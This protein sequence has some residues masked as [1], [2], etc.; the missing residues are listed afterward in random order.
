MNPFMSS[1]PTTTLFSERT[2]RGQR[3]TA[4][5]A[6]IVVHAAVAGLVSFG[7]LYTPRLNSQAAQHYVVR[8]L[9]LHTPDELMQR[10]ASG[11]DYPGPWP[12][13]NAHAQ[14][15][16][17]EAHPRSLRQVAQAKPGPQTL[18]QPDLPTQLALTQP[19]PVPQIVI[20]SPSKALVKNIVAPKPEKPTAADVPPSLE[21]PNEAVNLADVEIAPAPL[22]QAKLPI[23]PSTTSPITVHAPDLAPMAPATVSQLSSQP[24]PVAVMSLSDLRMA[25]GAVTLPPVN[26]TAS[27]KAAGALAP[28][29]AKDSALPGNGNPAGA[30]GGP[31]AA[32]TPGSQASSSQAPGSGAAAGK[33]AG[34][35]SGP[36]QGSDAGAGQSGKGSS[37]KITLPKNGQ[38]G[39]VVVGDSLTD[40]YPEMGNVWSGRLAYTVYLH[41]GLSQS[42]IL[43]YALPR[44]ADAAA[45]GNATHIEAPWPYSIVRP[46]LAPGSIDADA[47]MVHGFVNQAGHFEALSLVFPQAFPQAQFLLDTLEKWQFRPASEDGQAARVEVLLIIPEELN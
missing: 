39:A 31:G 24:T 26:E 11:V 28:G 21:A 9:D 14:G 2:D 44:S 46:N 6:S 27:I 22:T 40:E 1:S 10:A 13:K 20:W 5:L 42:W 19:V 36:A 43:Q 29:Q 15:G 4:F 47:L 18:V 38:F 17:Q 45:G 32:K 25:D 3:P 34:A 30:A 16:K 41:V 12:K 7:F 37:T 35:A 23:P 8:H 33:P